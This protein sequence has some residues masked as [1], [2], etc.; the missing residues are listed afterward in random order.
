MSGVLSA[1]NSA[2]FTFIELVIALA[3]LALLGTIVI[4]NLMPARPGYE[5]K[6]FVAQLNG[7]MN[8]TAAGAIADGVVYQLFFDVKNK[9]ITIRKDSGRTDSKG[10]PVFV[11]ADI[12]Y[13]TVTIAIPEGYQFKNFFIEGADEVGG[14]ASK[15]LEIWFF[16]VPTGLCQSVIINLFDT[17][18]TARFEQGEPMSLVL[19]PF[20]AQFVY[21]E[22]FQKP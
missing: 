12:P 14:K 11:D 21:H 22:T 13:G 9:F 16:V 6:A 15:T 8:A 4:P 3:I 18:D 2:G 7:M 10:E 1:K 17:L 5:R 19:N 20:T